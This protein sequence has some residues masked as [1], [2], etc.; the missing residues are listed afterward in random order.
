MVIELFEIVPYVPPRLSLRSLLDCGAYRDRERRSGIL[1]KIAT[2]IIYEVWTQCDTVGGFSP[3]RKDQPWNLIPTSVRHEKQYTSEAALGPLS[4]IGNDN[5]WSSAVPCN[6]GRD[7]PLSVSSM[8]GR[9]GAA[10]PPWCATSVFW[11]SK[12]AILASAA[13]RSHCCR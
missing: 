2:Q 9:P 3:R 7:G 1:F 8:A 4:V 11:D 12:L 10:V 6:R 5:H 13:E